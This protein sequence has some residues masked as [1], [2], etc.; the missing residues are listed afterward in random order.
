M[1]IKKL[2]SVGGGQQQQQ[3][4]EVTVRAGDDRGTVLQQ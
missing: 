2:F 1:K 3:Q 4:E